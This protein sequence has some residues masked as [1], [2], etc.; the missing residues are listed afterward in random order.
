[1]AGGPVRDF[2]FK[3]L[4]EL[5][6][7]RRVVVWYDA[8]NEYAELYDAFARAELVKIDARRSALVARRQADEAWARIVDPANPPPRGPTALIYVPWARAAVEETLVHEPF[9]VYARLGAAFGADAAESLP[10]LARQAMPARAADIDKLYAAHPTVKLAQIEALAERS[11]FPFLKRALETEDAIEVGARVV[12]ASTT[13]KKALAEAGV[14]GDLTRLLAEA[15]GFAAPTHVAKLGKEFALWVLF[16]EFAFDVK[17]AVPTHAAKVPRAKPE[18]ERAIYALCD[19]LRGS[20]ASRD[21]YMSVAMTVQEDLQLH[22]IANEPGDWGDRDTFRAEDRSTLLWVQ[23]ECLASRLGKARRALDLRKKSIWLRDAECSQLWQLATRCL[24]LLEASERW[25]AR[26]IA[27]GRPVAEH[28]LGYVSP[29]DG[30]WRVDRCQRWLERAEVDCGADRQV[31]QPLLEHC[32]SVHRAVAGAGQAAFLEAV[33][34]EGWPPDGPRQTEVF[35]R[36]VAP[37]LQQGARVAYF[38]VDAMRYEMGRDLAEMLGKLGD[39]VVTGVRTVVPTTTPFGMAALLPGAEASFACAVA[40]GDVVPVVAGA[41]VADVSARKECFRKLLGDRYRDLRLDELQEANDARLREMLGKADLL[42]VRSDDIDKAGE[43][44]NLPSARRF[45]SSILDD[46]TRVAQRLAR[47]GVTRMVF[48][49]DHGHVLVP[50]I[51]PGDVVREPPGTWVASKRR[52]RLG[53]GAGTADGVCVVKARHLGLEGEVD[54]IAL[55]TGFRVFAAGA[56]YFHE[57]VSL[58]ECLVPVVT[59]SPKGATAAGGTNHVA[60]AYRHP[61]FSQ[62]VFIVKLKLTTVERSELEVRVVAVAPGAAQPV[63]K[64]A[65]CEARDPATGLIRL[66]VGVEEA[67][68]IRIDDDFAGPS[69]DVQALDAAGVGVVLGSLKLKNHCLD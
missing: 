59:L 45:M 50:E 56:A 14:L 41:H 26:V 28:L 48:A 31:L 8:Q 32:R 68:A 15:F 24:E 53:S 11:G 67:V 22:G 36:D 60:I 13:V 35:S 66:R 5:L 55:A 47:A 39:V 61:H 10:S 40:G 62:R 21:A 6:D 23:E 63:G 52:C 34:R 18:H 37:A 16:S 30:L 33:L 38:L 19:R 46:L 54:D 12:A 20:D 7:E 43:G 27:P 17:G 69:V 29:D 57:G 44:T 2:L 3:R 42:V 51:A 4:G 58:Q 1:M 49:A 65:D 64:A 25:R 9:E